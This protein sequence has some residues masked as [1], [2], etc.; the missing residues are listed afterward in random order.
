MVRWSGVLVGFGVFFWME[1]LVR[2]VK[3]ENGGERV[4]GWEAKRR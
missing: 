3:V 4:Y 1:L 2:W